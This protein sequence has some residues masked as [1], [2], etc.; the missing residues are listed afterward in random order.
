V[1]QGWEKHGHLPA[2]VLAPLVGRLQ[3]QVNIRLYPKH[4]R[5]THL[6]FSR[7]HWPLTHQSLHARAAHPSPSPS[8]EQVLGEKFPMSSKP[9]KEAWAKHAHTVYVQAHAGREGGEALQ[10][11][12][13][14]EADIPAEEYGGFAAADVAPLLASVR[15]E[16]PGRAAHE[17]CVSEREVLSFG[18]GSR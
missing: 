9:Q 7:M 6:H 17:V 1:L 3:Q 16:G 12:T 4:S 13:I 2:A 10:E 14:N 18:F 8:P 11:L 5:P 15:E